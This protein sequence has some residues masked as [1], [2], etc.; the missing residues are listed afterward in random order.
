[1]DRDNNGV[2]EVSDII[3]IYSAKKHPAVVEGR[4]TE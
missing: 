4:K 3:G 2:L 1:M